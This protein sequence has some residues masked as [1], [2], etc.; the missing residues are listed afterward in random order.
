MVILECI[1]VEGQPRLIRVGLPQASDP[2]RMA[3]AM[4]I[5]MFISMA[6]P[7]GAD[8]SVS[9]NDFGVLDELDET[10]SKRTANGEAIV[11]AEGA[12]DALNAV[13][14][15][16]R[17][18]DATDPLSQASS[19]LDSLELRDASPFEADHPR[20]YEF[21]MDASTQPDGWPYNLFET[22][23]SVQ[24][25]GLDNILGIGINTYAVYVN[26]TSRDNG[27]SHEAWVEGTFTGELLVGTDL[28][29]F[30]NYIDIDGDSV[31]DLSVGLTIQGI[32]T[33]GDGF[34]I[35]LGDCELTPSPGPGIPPVTVPCVEELWVRPT[36]QWK[37]TALNQN[38]FLWNNMSHLEVSL[39]KGLAFDLTLDD[40]ESYAI[41]IDTRFT[42][43]P[44]EFTLGVGLQ[45]MAFNVNAVITNTAGFITSLFNGGINASSLSL[46]SISAPYAIRVSNPDSDSS[47]R[48]S[49]CDDGT[50]YYD[51]FT[52]HK[53]ESHLHKCGFGLGVGFIRFDGYGGGTTAPIL[54]TA[55]I[56]VGFHPEEGETRIPNEVDITLRN[57]NLGANT[58]DTVEIFSDYGSDMYFHYFEDRSNTTEGDSPFGN[59][60]DSRTWI[61]GLPSGTLHPDEINAIFTMIGEAPGSANLPGEIPSRLSMMI[62]IKNFSGDNTNNVNDPTLPVN[63]AAPPNTLVAIVAT[64]S[65]DLLDYKSTFK[66]G[67]YDADS[68]SIQLS[69]ANVPKVIIVEGSFQIPESGLSRVSYDNPNLNTVAQIFDNALLTVIEVILDVGDVVNG[70]PESIVGTAGSSGGAVRMN[71]YN[72]VRLSLPA[73]TRSPMEIG[74]VSIAISSSD[75]PWLPDIDHILLSEDTNIQTVN[76]RLGVQEPLVPVAMSA[77][78][79]GISSVSHDYDPIN[80]VRQMELRGINGGPL[81]I[82]HLLHDDG[83]LTTANQ[84][85][86]TLSNRPSTF[87]VTQTAEALTYTA[88]APIGTITYGGN[89]DGQRNAIR[90][91]GLPSSFQLILGDTVGYVA[92]TP[93]ESIEVQ[94]TNSTQPLTMDGDHFRFWVNETSGEASLSTAISDV[95]SL[96]RLSPLDPG[97]KGPEGNSRIELIRANSAPMN[98]LMEDDTVY[99]DSFKGMNGRVAIDPLPANITIAYP[100]GVDSGG[101]ELPTFD[102]GDGVQALSFFLGDLVNFGSLVNDFVYST[103]VDLGGLEAGNEDMSLGLDLITGELF[104]VTMDIEKGSNVIDEPEWSHGIGMEVFEA[105]VVSFNLS[106]MPTYTLS[107][108]EVVDEALRDYKITPAE[109][110]LVLEVFE[111]TN[112]SGFI[113]LLLALE[114]GIVLDSE[115]EGVNLSQ[116][117]EQGITF[118]LRRSWHMRS[119]LPS[120]PTGRILLEYDFR[121]IGDLPVYEL[122]VYLEQWTPKRQQLS[123]I[124]NGLEGRDL[125]F[126]ISG[127]DTT[128]ANNVEAN[129]VF[130][131]QDNLT[132]PR[133]SIDMHYDLGTRLDSAHAT[134]IDRRELSRVEALIVGVPQETDFSTTI[135]DIFLIDLLVPSQYQI[136]GHSAESLMIQQ[137]R[138]VDG[139]WWPATAFMRDLP[140]EMHLAAQPNTEFDIR[141]EVSFQGMM[142]LDYRSN[143]DDMDLYLEATGRSVDTKGDVLMLAEDLPS[144]FVLEMTDDWGVRV[145]SSGDGVSRLYL[146]QTDVPSSPGVVVDRVEIIG[147]NL[148]S[149]TIHIYTGPFQYPLIVIDDITNGRIV[150]SA[151]ATVEPYHTTGMLEGYS[152]NG[153]AVLLDAQFTGILPTASSIGVN[154][155]VTDLSLV[156]T[157]TDDTVETRHIL[158]VEPITTVI[159][160][161]L[162]LIW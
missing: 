23:F 108:R 4:V 31:D 120:L 9:R 154:G 21:L 67:G 53:T 78:I 138:F 34:G 29:L 101:L 95:T 69:I 110:E 39:M 121:M 125:E 19:Y 46:T 143:T 117:E 28:V 126:V 116:W 48:Q 83:D 158:L 51:P 26:F 73:S 64:E 146:K 104:N 86:A 35:E 36:F 105:T 57:D 114:D 72:Q 115:I 152:F 148:Q 6:Q 153:R 3:V 43:P 130:S 90:L 100:S 61:R 142:E 136:D 147:Q 8:L 122:D 127:L 30:N 162:A 98:V 16:Q 15:A 150:A 134:F 84:Q 94:L 27:P 135:G 160:S 44:H 89:G 145:A 137:M 66:R 12:A 97:S 55:Y 155:M 139:F 151:E 156:G 88:S 113:P 99:E 60:T 92:A 71:C 42:Q 5:L 45:K 87:N 20:P 81:L 159:A 56:D 37:V 106:R 2:R 123:I 7:A 52:D 24:S 54:E 1:M 124:V 107:S 47:D 144:T 11:A 33:Q 75:Q 80:D 161:G 38:D 82:G 131:T 22:L 96:R 62:A 157:L 109:Y 10:L 58:F 70:L 50:G 91:N 133:V 140:G 13:D 85:S 63:P 18:V 132:V 32:I 118:E 119:W 40:S 111:N 25:L 112:I 141:S 59:T 79:G 93:M 68:S 149:A 102:E 74:S 14:L 65:I 17:P 103:V 49:D 41:V 129:A 76:G 128:E 77:R